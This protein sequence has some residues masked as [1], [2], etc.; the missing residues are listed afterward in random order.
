MLSYFLFYI[1]YK[2]YNPSITLAIKIKH[3][4]NTS[5]NEHFDEIFSV[6][7]T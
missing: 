2:P 4:I 5:P 1:L 6:D 7:Q 3:S